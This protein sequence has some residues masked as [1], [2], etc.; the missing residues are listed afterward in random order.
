MDFKNSFLRALPAVD[1]ILQEE[2][3]KKIAERIPYKLLLEASQESIDFF[4]EKIIASSSREE[5]SNL[6]MDPGVIAAE[7]A[8]RAKSRFFS[9]LRP[10]INA[11]GTILHTNLGRAPLADQAVRAV[12]ST[13]ECYSNLELSLE[14]GRRDSRLAHVEGLICTLTGAEAS[15]VVNNNAAAVFLVLNT[16]AEG[17]EVIVSRGQLVEIGGGFRVPDVMKASGA[18]LV[19]VGTTNKCYR[20]DYERAISDRTALLMKVHTSN[21]RIVGFTEEV[22][23]Q[24][25]VSLGRQVGLPVIE[26]LGSGAFY[27]LTAYGLPSEPTVQE[28]LAEGIA[29]VTF[30]GD[31]ILGGPQAG[32]IVGEK[33]LIRRFRDNQLSRALRVDKL[34]LAALEA[35]LRLYHDPEKA[36]YEIPVLRMLTADTRDLKARAR[37]LW[38]HLKNRIE[39]GD[40][41][42]KEGVSYVGG[43]AMPLAELPTYLISYRPEDISLEELMRRLRRGN[44]P[45][46]ARVQQE[47]LFLDIRTILPGQEK[48]VVTTMMNAINTEE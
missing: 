42:I 16:L 9:G 35:T 28:C 46:I 7:A 45:L 24:E 15:L 23:R 47:R 30:S 20:H 13:A 43:G 3:L 14:N 8:E 27:D 17:R 38:R 10:V 11:T 39:T 33:D 4:R 12:T 26:D 19:E 6:S 41:E 34:T 5:L 31:K 22:S 21:Y 1:R 29:A 25:L 48:E 32:I 44:P 37:R 2:P 36:R 18:T 40:W